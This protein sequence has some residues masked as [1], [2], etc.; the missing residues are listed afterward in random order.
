MSKT[1]TLFCRK[2]GNAVNCVVSM[3]IFWVNNLVG[4]NFYAFCNY[5]VA[6]PCT[7]AIDSKQPRLRS[8]FAKELK[9]IK[10]YQTISWNTIHTS[11]ILSFTKSFTF[12]SSL[13]SKLEEDRSRYVILWRSWGQ[14]WIYMEVGQQ[15]ERR[16]KQMLT[17]AS[18]RVEHH[19]S[20]RAKLYPVLLIIVQGDILFSW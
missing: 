9:I 12:P 3:P 11:M 13:C 8:R 14:V 17:S 16:S 1:F 10:N 7:G 18:N 5:D 19:S 15:S 2:F 6:L 4:A 20:A